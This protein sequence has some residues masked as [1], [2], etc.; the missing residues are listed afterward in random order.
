VEGGRAG[1]PERPWR[2]GGF[3]NVDGRFES[4]AFLGE[5]RRDGA[6]LLPEVSTSLCRLGEP[7]SF[8][9]SSRLL[10]LAGS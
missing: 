5:V 10:R 2:R 4:T 6:M 8:S 1:F 7:R 3:E 9:H